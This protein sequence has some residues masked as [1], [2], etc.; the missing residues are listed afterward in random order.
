VCS[1]CAG[2]VSAI[3]DE[4]GRLGIVIRRDPAAP[5]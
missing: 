5:G 4:P 2:V 3:D 1:P